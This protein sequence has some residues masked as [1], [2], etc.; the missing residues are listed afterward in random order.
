MTAALLDRLA[1][2]LAEENAALL[3]SGGGDHSGFT[4]RKNKLLLDLM[5]SQQSGLTHVSDARLRG[6]ARQVHEL[7]DA[8]RRLLSAHLDAARLVSRIIVDSM[9]RAESDGTYGRYANRRGS[10]P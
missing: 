6:K 9:Q 5:R 3:A 4:D 1:G 10:S 8:N 2:L 7:L